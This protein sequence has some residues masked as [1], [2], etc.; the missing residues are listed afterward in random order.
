MKIKNC[1]NLAIETDCL[2]IPAL[3]EI[4]IELKE[5]EKIYLNNKSIRKAVE[6]GYIIVTRQTN[7]KK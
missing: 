7:L 4:V 3:G 5:W 2:S 6:M 1:K